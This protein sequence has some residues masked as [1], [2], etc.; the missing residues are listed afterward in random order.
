MKHINEISF[1]GSIIITRNV[2][3]KH[4]SLFQNLILCRQT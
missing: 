2:N 3:I 1:K 4:N